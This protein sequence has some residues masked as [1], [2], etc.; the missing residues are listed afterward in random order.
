MSESG[1]RG[2]LNHIRGKALLGHI[3]GDAVTNAEA[4]EIFS[5]LD[6]VE[7]AFEEAAPDAWDKFL[8]TPHTEVPDE[9]R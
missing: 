3:N 5:Y 8:A 9:Q 1:I 6:A 4:Q 2:R 7:L